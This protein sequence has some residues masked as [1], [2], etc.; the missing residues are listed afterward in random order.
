MDDTAL[1]QAFHLMWDNFPGM[2]RLINKKHIVLA[3]NRIAEKKGFVSGALCAKVGAAEIHRGCKM[4][5]VFKTGQPQVDTLLGDRLRGW[6]P[7]DG[8]QDVLVHFAV[9][10]PGI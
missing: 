4:A 2:A 7:V 10:L 9:M 6:L 8:R 1:I 3:A 5:I